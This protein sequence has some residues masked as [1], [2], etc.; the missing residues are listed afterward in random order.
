MDNLPFFLGTLPFGV[1]L[2]NKFHIIRNGRDTGKV[3]TEWFQS[4]L[5]AKYI[6]GKVFLFQ[7]GSLSEVELLY[8]V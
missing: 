1:S 5:K 7:K 8:S 3:K 6:S 4:C 2:I